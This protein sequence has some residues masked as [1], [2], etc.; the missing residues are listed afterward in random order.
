MLS[1][2]GRVKGGAINFIV[3]SM[4]GRVHIFYE[5]LH[6]ELFTNAGIRDEVAIVSGV[7][8]VAL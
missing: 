7:K 5:V 4:R 2:R 8:G 1:V 3:V 6:L